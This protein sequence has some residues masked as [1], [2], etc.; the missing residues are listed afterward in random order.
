MGELVDTDLQ[1]EI[2]GLY[3][4]DTSFIPE[5]RGLPPVL[6]LVGLGKRLVAEQLTA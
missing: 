6:M 4:C 1:S 3:V 2:A 5:P